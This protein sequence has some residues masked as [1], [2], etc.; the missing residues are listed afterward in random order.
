LPSLSVLRKS[1]L[2]SIFPLRTTPGAFTVSAARRHQVAAR[3]IL[4]DFDCFDELAASL[5]CSSDR[6]NIE[7]ISA[8][9]QKSI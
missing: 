4:R 8:F 6:A 3:S 1:A 2:Y 5:A 9:F 7:L